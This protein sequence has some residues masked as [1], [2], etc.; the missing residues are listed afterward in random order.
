MDGIEL[1][2]EIWYFNKP[3]IK[4]TLFKAANDWDL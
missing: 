4:G 1:A 3:K 2:S